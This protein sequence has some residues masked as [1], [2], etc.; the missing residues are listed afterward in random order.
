MCAALKNLANKKVFTAPEV[1]QEELRGHRIIHGLLDTYEPLLRL[2]YD[3]FT[4][5]ANDEREAS[6]GHE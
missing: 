3:D 4:G 1:I 6:K 5:I 2:C